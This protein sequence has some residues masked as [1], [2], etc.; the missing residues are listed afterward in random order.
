MSHSWWLPKLSKD[1]KFLQGK[2]KQ[3]K[4]WS[5]VFQVRHNGKGFYIAWKNSTRQ[6][7]GTTLYDSWDHC[8]ADLAV[9]W[10]RLV[11]EEFEREVLLGSEQN[12]TDDITED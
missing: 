7:D 9:S 11:D 5:D 8:R 3:M 6:V 1:E 2:K 4:E 12:S 10:R